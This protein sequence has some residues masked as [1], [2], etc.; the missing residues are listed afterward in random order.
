MDTG[1]EVVLLQKQV[2]LLQDEV[3]R[4]RLRGEEPARG[5]AEPGIKN[6]PNGDT[7]DV[8]KGKKVQKGDFCQQKRS[9]K[10]HIISL[11][12]NIQLTN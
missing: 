6:L 7:G 3:T 4:L 2:Q 5:K 1:G 8:N 11:R 12:T 10:M 9:F